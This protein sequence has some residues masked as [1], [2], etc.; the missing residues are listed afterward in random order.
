MPI[1]KKNRQP[2]DMAFV[3]RGEGRAEP[4]VRTAED[5]FGRLDPLVA[6]R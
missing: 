4:P 6:Q 3:L 1:P 5:A 2:E